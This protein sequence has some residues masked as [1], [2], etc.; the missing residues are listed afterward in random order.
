M[1]RVDFYVLPASLAPERFACTATAQARAEGG[2]IYIHV[3]SRE[4]AV[5]LD[6]LLWTFR[7]ISFLPHALADDNGP[8]TVPVA[9]GWPGQA[10][11]SSEVLINLAQD[12]PSFAASFARIVEPVAAEAAL[13]ERARE[14]FRRYRDMG[15]ELHSHEIED[16]HGD[17]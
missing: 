6:D 3:Q 1:P 11:R 16:E 10:P 9:I 8:G 4:E 13:R 5:T 17:A 15:F 2:D 14:R 12:V 7:D